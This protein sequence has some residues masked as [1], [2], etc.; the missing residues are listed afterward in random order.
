MYI[1]YSTQYKAHENSLLYGYPIL[2][3][4]EL[5]GWDPGIFERGGSTIEF[6]L[7][8]GDFFFKSGG[9]GGSTLKML[10]FNPN[11]A[12]FS[13]EGGGGGLTPG[14]PPVDPPELMTFRTNSPSSTGSAR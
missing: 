6:G 7:Q 2:P 1:T 13:E 14:I 8:R 11:L 4:V 5:G 3:K 10:Y 9:G 12:T